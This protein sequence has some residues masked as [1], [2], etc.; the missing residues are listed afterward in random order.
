MGKKDGCGIGNG[1]RKG[2][3]QGRGEKEEIGGERKKEGK[4]GKWNDRGKK[5]QMAE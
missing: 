3:E 2:R 4:N 5:R 1:D